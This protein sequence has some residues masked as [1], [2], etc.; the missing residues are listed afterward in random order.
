MDPYRFHPRSEYERRSRRNRGEDRWSRRS[1]YERD[2]IDPFEGEGERDEL[3][4]EPGRGRQ[5]SHRGPAQ[6]RYHR[7]FE[8]LEEWQ[9][10]RQFARPW[11]EARRDPRRAAPGWYGEDSPDYGR[12]H[13]TRQRAWDYTSSDAERFGTRQPFGSGERGRSSSG[14]AA[15]SHV[16]KGPK[17]YRRSDERIQEELSDRLTADPQIDASEL[18]VSVRQGEV[19]LEG[20]VSERAM[21]RVAEDLAEEINGVQEVH[22]RL[23][24][25]KRR[26]G[27]IDSGAE[28]SMSSRVG[29]SHP[30]GAPPRSGET[31]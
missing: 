10:P 11:D 5:E 8:D 17:G 15:E 30:A 27:E 24:V 13:A 28:R 6:G 12:G 16:G 9:R 29:G 31:R 2:P 18:S 3:E 20:S 1:D 26:T 19:I 23:R 4:F 25:E 22:N 14:R 7:G 21:K